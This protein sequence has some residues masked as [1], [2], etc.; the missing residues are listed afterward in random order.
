MGAVTEGFIGG[1]A[2]AAKANGTTSRQ[3]KGF[4]SGIDDFEVAFDADG[5]VVIDSDFG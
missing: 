5:A 4:A 1:L 2:A 3:A